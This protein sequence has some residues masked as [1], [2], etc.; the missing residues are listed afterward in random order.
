MA[1]GVFAVTSACDDSTGLRASF[2][3]RELPF[4]VFPVNGTAQTLPAG[5]LIRA[6]ELARV[7]SR[8]AF[9]IAFDMDATGKVTVHSV[10]ALASEVL[11]SVARIGLQID[12]S[13]T[14]AEITRAPGGGFAYDTSLTLPI[15]KTLLIDKLDPTCAQF[16]G[17]FLGYNIKAKMIIDSINL[18]SRSI[19]VHMLSN[20]NCGFRSLQ[21]G[22][23]E[24]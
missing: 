2:N 22:L 9:D 10:R 20:P 16:G 4:T 6:P 19:F 21:T 11:A 17:G 12:S 14:Y 23:P 3:N 15:G 18:A 5:I 24:E 1:V 13:R 7:D 8:W